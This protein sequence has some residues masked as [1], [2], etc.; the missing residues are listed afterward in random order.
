MKAKKMSLIRITSKIVNL[1]FLVLI[2]SFPLKFYGLYVFI[3]RNGFFK[4]TEIPFVFIIKNHI[5]HFL[6]SIL[7][8]LIFYYLMKIFKKLQLADF[9]ATE[10]IKN[11][12]RLGTITVVSAII[13][14]ILSVF[15]AFSLNT[16]NLVHAIHSLGF[17]DWD[18][19]VLG[20]VILAVAE[21]FKKG[22]QLDSEQRLVV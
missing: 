1:L 20:L 7:I 4:H 2:V 21:S 9:F 5:F 6:N 11:L 13:F 22:E 18:N 19:L 15:E 14:S 3:K 10:N 12:K 16:F 17:I 8:I